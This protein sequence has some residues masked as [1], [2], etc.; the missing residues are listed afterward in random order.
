VPS[1]VVKGAAAA[2]RVQG[3]LQ[4]VRLSGYDDWLPSQL[5]GGRQ[6]RVALARAPV[7]EPML[8]LLD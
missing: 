7:I 3:A 2:A 5:S 6:Q 1:P 8:L 4:L